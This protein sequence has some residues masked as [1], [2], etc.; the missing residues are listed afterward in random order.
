M[1]IEKERE[2][3]EGGEVGGEWIHVYG[4]LSLHLLFTLLIISIPQYK[5]FLVLR[6]IKIKKVTVG[7][8][9]CRKALPSELVRLHTCPRRGHFPQLGQ[10]KLSYLVSRSGIL[11]F[12]HLPSVIGLKV[13]ACGHSRHRRAPE[14][15]L[16]NP[17]PFSTPRCVVWD[18]SDDASEGG[19]S[20]SRSEEVDAEFLT[21]DPRFPEGGSSMGLPS[22]RGLLTPF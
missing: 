13:P 3:K 10:K 5:T 21:G 18:G 8:T 7:Q 1:K 16:R 15:L 6:K 19:P 17:D 14:H 12:P 22:S 4:W 9:L 11:W 2:K 20:V